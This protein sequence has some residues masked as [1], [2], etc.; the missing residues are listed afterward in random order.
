MISK[1][2]L[3]LISFVKGKKKVYK[4][5]P[6]K[7]ICINNGKIKIKNT[8]QQSKKW[9]KKKVFNNIYIIKNTL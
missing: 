3:I 4:F 2:S 7:V 1:G 5:L 8:L 9:G 6:S